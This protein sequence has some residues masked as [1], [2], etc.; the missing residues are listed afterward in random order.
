MKETLNFN[1][2]NQENQ[3]D[4]F[5][6]P[7]EILRSGERVETV[8]DA[9]ILDA[10]DS[11]EKQDDSAGRLKKFFSKWSSR[12]L[13]LFTVASA[14]YVLKDVAKEQMFNKYDFSSKDS[15]EQ[16]NPEVEKGAIPEIVIYGHRDKKTDAILNCISGKEPLPKEM[17]L[18]MNARLFLDHITHDTP[19]LYVS[20]KYPSTKNE[21]KEQLKTSD[22][23]EF[24]DS[25][26]SKLERMT[27]P[28][29]ERYVTTREHMADIVEYQLAS[30]PK[31]FIDKYPFKGESRK[32]KLDYLRL[33][34]SV[35]HASKEDNNVKEMPDNE[36][37]DYLAG[38][39]VRK[40]GKDLFF[41][42]QDEF[43][44][45]QYDAVWTMN[46]RHGNPS[47][48]FTQMYTQD[49]ARGNRAYYNHNQNKIYLGTY[50]S[51]SEETVKEW[52]KELSHSVQY[53]VMP[54]STNLRSNVDDLRIWFGAL[55]GNRD[56]YAH[57]HQEHTMEHE[58]HE[59]I[60]PQL[61]KEWEERT[62]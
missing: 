20:D 60:E 3:E 28:E 58:A 5:F 40:K 51:S 35:L 53:D 37:E 6:P 21:P 16:F 48:D 44:V 45:K 56:K 7:Q 25:L 32:D 19:D 17:E 29:V 10:F 30:L 41:N 50:K 24:A 46:Q 49:Y 8:S 31:F 57:Y 62:K 13:L 36:F 38:L 34:R 59:E 12:A 55:V 61:L 2:N 23:W 15:K 4:A 42:K 27:E 43:S 22:L 52:I 54:A 9:Q 14:S 26:K 11:L 39:S 18:E 33:Y 1:Q 47:V